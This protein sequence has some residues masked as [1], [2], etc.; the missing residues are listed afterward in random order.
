MSLPQLPF[1]L[2][3]FK[4][5]TFGKHQSYDNSDRSFSNKP[6]NKNSVLGSLVKLALHENDK[7]T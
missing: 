3:I 1:V 7:V 2:A 5:N 4:W 6:Y